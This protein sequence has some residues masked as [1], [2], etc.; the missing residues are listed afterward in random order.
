MNA[1]D[2]SENLCQSIEI[3][4]KSLLKDL[5]FDKT[6]TC[7]I[8]DDSNRYQGIYRVKENNKISY[9]AYSENTSYKKDMQVYV[10]IPGSDYNNQKIITG[11]KVT[12]NDAPVTYE[13]P[14]D[15]VVDILGLKTI[16]TNDLKKGLIANCPTELFQNYITIFELESYDKP[17]YG[18]SKIAL[19]ADF[20]SWLREANCIMGDYGLKVTIDF[21]A[22]QTAI[23]TEDLD[24]ENISNTNTTYPVVRKEMFLS[25]SDMVGNPYQFDTYFSQEKAFDISAYS[26]LSYIKV[27]FYQLPDSFL[28]NQKN[29][30]GQYKQLPYKNEYDQTLIA[31]NLFVQN[32]QIAIGYDLDDKIEDYTELY[33]SD[34]SNYKSKEDVKNIALKW[35]YVND[36]N[37]QIVM[38]STIE[39]YIYEIRWYRYIMGQPAADAYVTEGW[40]NIDNPLNKSNEELETDRI[41]YKKNNNDNHAF[42]TVLRPDAE[43]QST[44]QIRAIILIGNPPDYVKYNFSDNIEEAKV[45]YDKNPERYYIKDAEN[46]DNFINCAAKNF[47]ENE[48]YYILAADTR[49][50]FRTKT[51]SFFN[52]K[53]LT[54]NEDEET[55][56][57]EVFIT[58]ECFEKDDQTTYF[59]NGIYNLYG[60][61]GQL[62]NYKEHSKIRGIKSLCYLENEQQLILDLLKEA[63]AISW[64]IPVKNTMIIDK[65]TGYSNIKYLDINKNMAK[66]YDE[67]YYKEIIYNQEDI[68]KQFNGNSPSQPH[69]LYCIE[70]R[71]TPEKTNNRII[72]Y[73]KI[74]DNIYSNSF[75]LVFNQYN[76]Y[77]N[78]YIFELLLDDNKAVLTQGQ[79]E[80]INITPKL[81]NN[82]GED[83]N[84]DGK[85]I[86]W[87]FVNPENSNIGVT[88]LNEDMVVFEGNNL[89]KT[90]KTNSSLS[91]N[92]NCIVKATLN[93]NDE[94]LVAYKSIPIRDSINYISLDGLTEI[95]YSNFE[96]NLFFKNNIPYTLYKENFIPASD[97]EWESYFY[98]Q[99][100]YEK[101]MPKITK[102]N[103]LC[104]LTLLPA[105][106]KGLPVYSIQAVDKNT[107]KVLW[108]QPILI[109]QEL[110]NNKIIK[111]LSID[112]MSLVE[113]VGYLTKDENDKIKGISL[114][115]NE[116]NQCGL[117]GFYKDK[118]FC[119]INDEGTINLGQQG[120]NY[121][122]FS[123]FENIFQMTNQND[124]NYNISI[125]STDDNLESNVLQIGDINSPGFQV[126]WN[127][128]TTI[129]KAAVQE[130][131][132]DKLILKD[133]LY[134][135]ITPAEEL[136]GEK[137]EVYFYLNPNLPSS[138]NWHQA[139]IWI[140]D[141]REK[142][143]GL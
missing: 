29:D 125:Q 99:E 100:N 81:Y 134:K 72:C 6:V 129:Q 83:I 13:S 44:E 45:E 40:V 96:N 101:F 60:L 90:I 105:Y 62:I 118:C 70:N 112:S 79:A 43:N 59:S 9:L 108:N 19:K 5:S 46:P 82:F 22:E 2:Y 64:I 17:Y 4:S 35:I 24:N 67:I 110:L 109:Q 25:A 141:E 10:T 14:F 121:L 117:F 41:F 142:G 3:I 126:Q 113:T 140:Y 26:G 33:S 123:N 34:Q 75:E 66:D 48:T 50:I 137:G 69:M 37:Q 114:A 128:E 120:F 95:L 115:K 47:N 73:V 106:I 20:Q 103:D 102:K 124:L 11:K 77:N 122:R 119:E 98:N 1:A 132:L 74:N 32:C 54:E 94:T 93:V 12:E 58:L 127:G 38:N 86:V 91:I 131:Q 8:I 49:E 71:F 92:T 52:S 68:Q 65:S 18:F 55:E 139:E 7:T 30:K 57:D 61:D 28:I 42:E 111:S 51:L 63:T 89:T 53:V 97:I 36:Y 39:E 88:S 15:S 133:N 76:I 23:K 107:R 116:N 56:K 16:E 21:A 31:P 87:E 143:E 138:G 135:L 80:S 78:N 136:L 85:T 104:Y 84:L 130:V 27:E